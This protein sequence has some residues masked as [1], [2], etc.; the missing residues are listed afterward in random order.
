LKL[1]RRGGQERI[2]W[3]KRKKGGGK[4]LPWEKK[5]TFLQSRTEDAARQ[6]EESIEKERGKGKSTRK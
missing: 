5:E 1:R 4:N 6:K 3:K 2:A